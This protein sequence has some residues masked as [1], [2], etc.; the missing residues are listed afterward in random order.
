MAFRRSALGEV[1]GFETSPGIADDLDIFFRILMQGFDLVYDPRSVVRHHLPSEG[2]D[3]RRHLFLWSRGYVGY[4]LKVARNNPLY[5]QPALREVNRWLSSREL[6]SQK[7]G[8]RKSRLPLHLDLATLSG[9][10]TALPQRIFFPALLPRPAG[11]S[12]VGGI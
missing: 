10:M 7:E 3:L 5:R 11:Q 1:N 9:G 6:Q 4:L 12:G 8:L 2:R